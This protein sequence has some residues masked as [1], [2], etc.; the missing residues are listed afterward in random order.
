[1]ILGSHR[2]VVPYVPPLC[3]GSMLVPRPALLSL[4][5]GE[6][7]LFRACG[8]GMRLMYC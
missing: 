6:K 4:V 3:L 2:D 7:S 5:P 1:M 8:L